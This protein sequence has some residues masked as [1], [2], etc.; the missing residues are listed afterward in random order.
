[1]TTRL[2]L[3]VCLAGALAFS[4]ATS[5]NAGK[6]NRRGPAPHR[7]TGGPS[8]HAHGRHSQQI[9]FQRP[10][11]AHEHL[12]RKQP[13]AGH[14]I[15]HVPNRTRETAQRLS[16]R[17]RAVQAQRW[18]EEQKRQHRLGQAQHLRE[19]GARNGNP[20]LVETADRME[21]MAQ[22][23]FEQRMRQIERVPPLVPEPATEPL[24]RQR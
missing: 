19:L 17:E 8:G 21:Q 4:L 7:S 9:Y 14:P 10:P 15:A 23:H 2:A 11:R 5:V 6:E 3:M 1:M 22:E 24:P 12:R 18:N 16:G 20:Q 13:P